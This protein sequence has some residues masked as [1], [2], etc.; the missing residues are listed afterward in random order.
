[1]VKNICNA[2]GVGT[3]RSSGC[4]ERDGKGVLQAGVDCEEA[5]EVRRERCLDRFGGRFG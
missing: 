5:G 4:S 1:V 2:T 3:R